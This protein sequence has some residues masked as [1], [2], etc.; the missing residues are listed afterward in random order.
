MKFKVAALQIGPYK[1]SYKEQ[2]DNIEQLIMQTIKISGSVDLICLPELMTSPHFTKTGDK[3]WMDI[4]EPIPG[5][6]TFLRMSKI[7]TK[8]N[9]HILAT[10]YE[11][12]NGKY[13]NSAFIVSPSGDL[14]GT[15][16]KVHVPNNPK[17]CGSNEKAYFDLGPELPVFNV[18]GVPIGI[19]ICY[20]RSFPEAW[21]TLAFKG[22]KVI[23]VPTSSCGHRGDLYVQELRVAAAQHQVYAIGA[24][25]SGEEFI[26]DQPDSMIFYGKSTIVDPYGNIVAYLEQEKDTFIKADLDID[27]VE[28]S[29]NMMLYYKDK[30]ND[31]YIR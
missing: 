26:K 1:G 3:A 24:N 2:L 8:I 19:L 5:G 16:A 9:C 20:D 30:R 11:L 23:V 4:A 28:D 13:Y 31:L 10:C 27:M 7:A 6:P 15:Y 18:R 17:S 14:V 25:K 12:R 21:H 29:R 22:A